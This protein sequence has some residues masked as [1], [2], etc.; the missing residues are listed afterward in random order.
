MPNGLARAV[1]VMSARLGT[2]LER[3]LAILVVRTN[4]GDED[5]GFLG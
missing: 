4:G 2:R 3:V 1:D 5:E